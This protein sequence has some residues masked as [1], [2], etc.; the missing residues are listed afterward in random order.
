MQDIEEGSKGVTSHVSNLCLV[1]EGLV[2]QVG[3]ILFLNLLVLSI[4]TLFI[5]IL[6]FLL[7]RDSAGNVKSHLH[8]LISSCGS[9]PA[10]ILGRT[11]QVTIC[12]VWYRL[13]AQIELDSYLILASK[14]RV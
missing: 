7:L 9:F 14:V 13:G 3:G 11:L 2:E 4:N 6:V 8:K 12:S 10:S 1:H 5:T